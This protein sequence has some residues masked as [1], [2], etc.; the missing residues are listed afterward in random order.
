MGSKSEQYERDEM[1]AGHFHWRWL[2]QAILF[3][4]VGVSNTAVDF[5]V[6]YLLT[7]FVLIDYVIAQIV[8]YGAGML[9][10]YLLNSKVTFA[11]SMHSRVRAIKFVV[12][13][14]AVLA[15]TLAAMHSMLFLPLYL[16]KVIS[17]L[18]GLSVN[19]IL[20]KRWVFKS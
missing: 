6:F 4:F 16:N 13:N 17:T 11:E 14:A 15:I 5:I 12:L 20:S 10:S 18:I 19:F 3:G 7:H 9:N 1:R 8:S 2:K